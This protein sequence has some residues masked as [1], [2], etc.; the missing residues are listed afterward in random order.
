MFEFGFYEK[1]I[2]PPL[3][4]NLPGYGNLRPG[5]DVK[6]RL[7]ARA[8]VVK[9]GN[10]AV[11]LISVDACTVEN[12]IVSLIT[13]RIEEYTGIKRANILIAYTHTHTG[14]PRFGYDEDEKAKANQEEYHTVT[15]KLIADCAILAYKRLKK[16]EIS[17][18]KGEVN[19][20]SFCRNYFI[21][22]ATPQTNPPRESPEIIGPC[23]DT[24]NEL[25]V[26]FV[27]D[28]KQNPMGAI[29][30]FA[31]HPDCVGVNEYSG[32]YISELSKQLKKIY[33]EEFVTVF[34]LG[35]CG[36]INH[37]D[38]T[39]SQDS[40]DHYK[41]MGQKIAG[42][43]A[44]VIS[45]ATTLKES[46]IKT[47]FETITLNRAEVSKEK[48]QEAQHAIATIKPVKGIKI[49]A[50]GT[51]P[52]QYHLMMSVALIDY[53]NN[54]PKKMDIPL[55]VIKIG[56][57]KIYA[58]PSEIYCYFGKLI[59]EKDGTGNCMVATLCNASFG[60]I[61][62][63]DIFYDTIYES[64]PGSNRLEREAGYIICEKLLDMSKKI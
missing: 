38:V 5:E 7:F 50:D 55:Q 10:E 45:F 60:Y 35:A 23:A 20:I 9:E 59:K 22:N 49:A 37:F 16:C 1:E 19:G 26:L 24:D 28:E 58:F 63:R 36:N 2:T 6:D 57:C 61:P 21:K 30:S 56:E 64:L 41:K 25:P 18:A 40:D 29:I 43:A 54:T 17:F 51:D 27:K 14:T 15:T 48:I 47:V 11:A 44:K 46:G 8:A 4:C 3:G 62:T 52:D 31:C 42:E 39:K 33:G 32:D 34:L 12:D 53:V 13:D